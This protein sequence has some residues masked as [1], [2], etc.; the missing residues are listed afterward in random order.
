MLAGNSDHSARDSTTIGS[1]LTTPYV[2]N[3]IAIFI[4]QSTPNGKMVLSKSICL[5]NVL[6]S[7]F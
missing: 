5:Y 6:V 4:I 2:P 7:F 3:C 1:K